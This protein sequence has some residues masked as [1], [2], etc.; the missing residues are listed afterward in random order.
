MS[1]TGIRNSQLNLQENRMNLEK[2]V[3]NDVMIRFRKKN[4]SIPGLGPTPT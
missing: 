2:D 3:R 4:V 1:N